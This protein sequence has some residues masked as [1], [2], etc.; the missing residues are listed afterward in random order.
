[1]AKKIL[2][3]STGNLTKAEYVACKKCH[4]YMSQDRGCPYC[5]GH[6]WYWKNQEGWTKYPYEKTEGRYA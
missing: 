4:Y 3:P 6:G 2:N 1:M 5:N